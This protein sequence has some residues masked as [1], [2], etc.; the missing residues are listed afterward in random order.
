MMLAANNGHIAV[1]KLLSAKEGGRQ[2]KNQILTWTALMYAAKAGHMNVIEH[3]LPIETN[4]PDENGRTALMLAACFW[5]PD[6]VTLLAKYEARKQDS[7]GR[8]ALMYAIEYNRIASVEILA[9]HEIDTRDKYDKTALDIAIAQHGCS[10]E[11]IRIL[12]EA[13]KAL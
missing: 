4:M 2:T 6:I 3:L 13:Q 10:D 9:P 1:V 11:I 7:N 12:K 8:T 5:N